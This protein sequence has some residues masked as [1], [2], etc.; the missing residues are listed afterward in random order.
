M[1]DEHQ[2]PKTLNLHGCAFCRCVRPTVTACEGLKT[3]YLWLHDAHSYSLRYSLC[4]IIRYGRYVDTLEDIENAPGCE[5]CRANRMVLE[6]AWQVVANEYFDPKSNFSQTWWAGEL[7]RVLKD[8][9]GVITCTP[10][11]LPNVLTPSVGIS[12]QLG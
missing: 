4:R 10:A 6:H 2:I 9:G 7:E 1:D 12:G 5:K 11:R 3:M 8:H